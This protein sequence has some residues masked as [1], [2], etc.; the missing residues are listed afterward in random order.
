MD[1][2]RSDTSVFGVPYTLFKPLRH[3]PNGIQ[4]CRIHHRLFVVTAARP[5]RLKPKALRLSISGLRARFR[6]RANRQQSANRSIESGQ[7]YVDLFGLPGLREAIA[8]FG[9]HGL[10]ADPGQIVVTTG[11]VGALSLASR[12]LFDPGDE[13]LLLGPAMAHTAISQS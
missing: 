1:R 7:G 12:A 8:A 10:A 11:S 9:K 3:V 2:N 4:I 5:T 13:V 6:S